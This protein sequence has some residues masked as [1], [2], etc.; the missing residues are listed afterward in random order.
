MRQEW[1]YNHSTY[2]GF[3]VNLEYKKMLI[4]FLI[5][6]EV[7][8]LEPINGPWIL[9]SSDMLWVDYLTWIDQYL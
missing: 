1:N 6:L 2:R 7:N 5:R 9:T 3:P 4:F 8:K